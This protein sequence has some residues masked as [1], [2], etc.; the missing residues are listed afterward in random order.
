VTTNTLIVGHELG[1]SI[2][3]SNL[4][5]ELGQHV[6]TN[7]TPCLPWSGSDVAAYPG[8]RSGDSALAT[9][10]ASSCTKPQC[11]GFFN[12]KITDLIS[13]CT[14]TWFATI[15]PYSETSFIACSDLDQCGLYTYSPLAPVLAS[16][17]P[18]GWYCGDT[19]TLACPLSK[20]GLNPN[21][22]L[23]VR[24]SFASWLPGELSR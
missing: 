10:C 19:P 14:G 9:S 3:S 17:V 24:L 8:A 16:S 11:T 6:I 7:P 15:Q 20:F 21:F 23:S 5:L 12:C 18:R 2:Y 13:F 1:L 4:S 22:T